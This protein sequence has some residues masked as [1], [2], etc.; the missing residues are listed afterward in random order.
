[1]NKYPSLYARLEATTNADWRGSRV[2]CTATQ[3]VLGYIWW[4]STARNG[5]IWH[6]RSGNV[7]GERNTERNAVQSL[8]DLSNGHSAHPLPPV[9]VAPT[10]RRPAHVARP[11][12]APVVVDVAP[13]RAPV[14]RVLWGD[15][16]TDVP[17]L[18]AAITNA[19]KRHQKETR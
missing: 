12:V 5:V 4:S 9:D 19:F 10:V 11:T 1:M 15:A 16:S 18:T 14:R 8:R 13:T 17:D 3:R 2:V 7:T 6:F